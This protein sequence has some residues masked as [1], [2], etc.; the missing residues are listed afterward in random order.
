MIKQGDDL[1]P[2]LS[3]FTLEYAINR[4]QVNQEGLILNGVHQLVIY[5]DGACILA[6]SIHAVKKNRNSFL[7]ASRKNGVDVN[8]EKSK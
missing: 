3:N 5:A 4:I 8:A 6:G 1:S 2:L 7:V